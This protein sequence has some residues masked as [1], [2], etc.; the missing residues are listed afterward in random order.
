M[1]GRLMKC[2]AITATVTSATTVKTVS[3]ILTRRVK[4]MLGPLIPP[5]G[6]DQRIAGAVRAARHARAGELA[7]GS[8]PL[9]LELGQI[10]LPPGAGEDSL[11]DAAEREVD[12]GGQIGV[13]TA[14]E[15][16]EGFVR[17]GKGGKQAQ[18]SRQA[19]AGVGQRLQHRSDLVQLLHQVVG[20]L[21]DR[22]DRQRAE[23]A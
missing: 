23:L 11:V 20:G 10:A 12:D 18:G 9:Q 15:V 3:W 21:I 2:S 4:C 19:G 13:V 8:A 14:L 5:V 16:F 6:D 1:A 22:V 7:D 17:K